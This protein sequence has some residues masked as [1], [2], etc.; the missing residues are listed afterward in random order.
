[1]ISSGKQFPEYTI[2]TQV[3]LIGSRKH[4]LVLLVQMTDLVISNW[5]PI[6][7]VTFSS[8]PMI[9]SALTDMDDG[10]CSAFR[11]GRSV[12]SDPTMFKPF[13]HLSIYLVYKPRAQV[14]QLPVL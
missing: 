10:R 9:G 8:L 7:A 11:R 13:M 4:G 14:I 3:N 12:N 6:L 2:G 1:M 5:E